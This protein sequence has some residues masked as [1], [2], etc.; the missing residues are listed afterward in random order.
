MQ[1]ISIIGAGLAGSEAAWQAVQRG[2]AVDL[3]EMRPAKMTPAHQ[4]ADFAELVCSNS[5]RAASL[6]NAVGLL[7]EEMRRLNSLIMQAADATQV[8][9]GGALAVDRELFANYISHRLKKHSL[10]TVHE[11]EVK[12]IP[13]GLTI[14]AAGPLVSETLSRQIAEFTGQDQLFF[15]DAIAPVIAKES[16]DLDKAFFASRYGKGETKGDYINCPFNRQ[17]YERFYH[18]LVQAELYPLHGFEKPH[19]FEGCM[20]IETLAKRGYETMRYGPM[21]PVGLPQPGGDLAYAVLQLRQDDQ[22]ATMYNMVGFQTRLKQGEQERVFRLIPG[23]ERAE[24]LRFGRMHLN[25][26]INAPQILRSDLVCKK[27]PDLL[28]AGQISGV[29]GYVE[30]AASGLLAG[31]NAARL[32]LH[33]ETLILPRETALGSLLN[34]ISSPHSNFQ[35]MNITFGLLPPPAQKIRNKREKNASI[36]QRALAFLAETE[37]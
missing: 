25:T 17:E 16:I 37:F 4:T 6:N 19:V 32:A 26:Y 18:E 8:P 24:F 27:R 3:Y 9:A 28:F 20:P 14:I 5:L 15:H 13:P 21:K 22:A 31:I 30:S 1:K 33:K 29:E 34:Y 7:K 10:V 23:L 36:A 11:L 35:P 12:K 2:V